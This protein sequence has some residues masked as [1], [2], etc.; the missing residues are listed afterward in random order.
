MKKILTTAV[1]ILITVLLLL[2]IFH[3]AEKRQKMFYALQTAEFIWIFPGL[4][5]V[6]IALLLQTERWRILLKVQRIPLGWWRTLRL[7]MVGVFFNL[8]LLGATGGDIVKIFYLM[9]E[10]PDKKSSIFLSVVVD[11]VL[12]LIGLILVAIVLSFWR[13]NVLY[14]HEE[15]RRLLGV[16]M[17]IL[18]SVLAILVVA[19]TI[20]RLGWIDRLP[21]WIPLRM[22]IIELGTAFSLYARRTGAILRAL[23]ISVAGHLFLFSSYFF[24]S[25]A[26]RSHLSLLDVFSV[27]PVVLT[28]ASLPISLSGLGV[29]E[30]LFETMLYVLY[31]TPGAIA[32]LI[33]VTG[34]L[35]NMFWSLVGGVVYLFYR[36][37]R[38]ENLHI[39]DMTQQVHDLEKRFDPSR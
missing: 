28:M 38:A 15:T 20:E 16:L 11:R 34:F 1:Q 24:A 5:C 3:D 9:R 33:S 14:H 30:G 29:R 10:V 25:L 12:G 4:I 27:L 17:L 36:P 21:K 7:N 13:F 22:Y 35:L 18:C 31:G 8:F 23:V 2:W 19:F 37:S 39:K 26:F 6:G 32:V